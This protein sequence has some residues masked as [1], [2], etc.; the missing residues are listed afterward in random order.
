MSSEGQNRS[1]NSRE[2]LAFGVDILSQP[3]LAFNPSSGVDA[4]KLASDSEPSLSSS[5]KWS[6]VYPSAEL[7]GLREM[8]PGSRKASGTRGLPWTTVSRSWMASLMRTIPTINSK[9]LICAEK[10][11]H[12]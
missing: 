7:S 1:P 10:A 4:G 3:H 12:A 11:L 8:A 6:G 9:T 2:L 5:V